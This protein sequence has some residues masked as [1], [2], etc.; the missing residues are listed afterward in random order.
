MLLHHLPKTIPTGEIFPVEAFTTLSSATAALKMRMHVTELFT[1]ARP[2]QL[3]LLVLSRAEHSST[4]TT[5]TQRPLQPTPT[6]L[7]DLLKRTPAKHLALTS[8]RV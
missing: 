2:N 1:L 6:M 3:E 5:E 7:S 8:M 4:E